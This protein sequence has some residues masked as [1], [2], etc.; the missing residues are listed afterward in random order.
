MRADFPLQNFQGS[1]D[2]TPESPFF[3]RAA[4]EFSLWVMA[5]AMT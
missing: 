2:S 1:Q 5:L 4:F 3:V